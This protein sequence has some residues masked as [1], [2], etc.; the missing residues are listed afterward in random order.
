MSPPKPVQ[1]WSASG[2]DGVHVFAEFPALRAYRSGANNQADIDTSKRL[3]MALV[4][5]LLVHVL[6]YLGVSHWS[7]LQQDDSPESSVIQMRLIDESNNTKL[8]EVPPAPLPERPQAETPSNV[9]AS[10]P[11]ATKRTQPSERLDSVPVQAS[12]IPVDEEPDQEQMDS[13]PELF[14]KQGRVVMPAIAADDPAAFGARKPAPDYRPDPMSHESPLP[15]QPTRF[16]R[17]WKPDGET[18][19]G[20][21]VR[22]LSKE[23]SYD[24]KYGTRVTCKAFL[25]LMACGWGPAPRMSIEELRAMRADPP[26]PRNSADD[27]YL[28]PIP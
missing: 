23:S 1:S 24:T 18:L 16:D 22:K 10:V 8:G 11:I 14:D 4:A 25:F 7:L 26:A 28:A 27:P 21:W 15:Y 12:R 9:V 20:E 2:L 13:L 19:L 6:L 3:R 17:D 5:S